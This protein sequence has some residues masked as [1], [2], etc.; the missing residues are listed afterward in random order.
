MPE[1][2]SLAGQVLDGKYRLERKLGQGGMG[3]VFRATHLGTDRVV[4]LKLIVP[5]LMDQEDFVQRFQREARATG[6][7]R[8]PNIVDL[9]DFGF[10]ETGGEKVA[11]L[12]MEF[13][14][15]ESLADLLQRN[16]QPPLSFVVEVIQQVCSAL[17]EAHAKGIIH[18]DLKPDNLW[19]EPDRR[20]GQRV[21]ILDFGLAKIYDPKARAD[22]KPGLPVDDAATQALA[23]SLLTTEALPPDRLPSSAPT[24][25]KPL[26]TGV[27]TRLGTP[28]Y[29]SPEQCRGVALDHRSDLYSL[30]VIAYQMLSGRM[31][32]QGGSLDL[33]NQHIQSEVPHLRE[34]KQG[35]PLGVAELVMEC[36]SKDPARRPASAEILGNALEAYATD[37]WSMIKNGFGLYVDIFLAHAPR[38]LKPF[39]L[40]FLLA[41][42]F[43][44]Y[45]IH[46][47][48]PLGRAGGPQDQEQMWI[49]LNALGYLSS[50]GWLWL[51]SMVYSF[52]RQG[53]SITPLV[54]RK[55]IQPLAPVSPGTWARDRKAFK[56]YDHYI[57]LSSIP[58]VG[59]L[60]GISLLLRWFLLRTIS[61]IQ[62]LPRHSP[63][64]LALPLLVMGLVILVS[65]AFAVFNIRLHGGTGGGQAMASLLFLEGLSLKEAR[66]R[67]KALQRK[68]HT[69]LVPQ[70]FMSLKLAATLQ[71]DRLREGPG[72]MVALI[73]GLGFGVFV[74][75]GL[76]LW[77]RFLPPE[78]HY[79]ACA[80]AGWLLLWLTPF[81][82]L[83]APLTAIF[84]AL[85]YLRLRKIARESMTEAFKGFEARLS[86]EA[87][88]EGT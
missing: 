76:K 47:E 43:M 11:Y 21:K 77:D 69:Y 86:G 38:Y 22:G 88:P 50:I 39:L 62:S 78:L 15:G 28:A 7:L 73:L 3:A 81:L 44:A 18:R 27:G 23:P 12:V 31:P 72:T 45:A 70:Q 10:A 25:E 67:L 59:V 53:G 63:P 58:M 14:E 5:G 48:R 55:L 9:T 71:K 49:L 17:E 46:L 85:T 8:H 82:A 4:A 20:G 87:G 61:A 75:G 19:L 26:L 42:L 54:L 57:L 56:A 16:P 74:F 2:S 66:L 32:F 1:P 40:P 35:L 24:R 6:R 80:F 65:I 64:S 52:N 41:V 36:L 84:S 13:L 33:I 29:M 79:G 30:G 37:Q 83:L 68:A 51:G 34:A 60:V